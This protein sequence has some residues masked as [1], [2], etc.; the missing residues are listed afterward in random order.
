MVKGLFWNYYYYIFLNRNNAFKIFYSFN[1]MVFLVVSIGSVRNT[2]QCWVIW[3]LS[4]SQPSEELLLFFRMLPTHLYT[5]LW[6]LEWS[7][8]ISPA[9]K[10]DSCVA[11]S[12]GCW[13]LWLV[14]INR[15]SREAW[16][17]SSK[18][19]EIFDNGS[20]LNSKDMSVCVFPLGS[21][22]ISF[23]NTCYIVLI[24]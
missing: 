19:A 11:I 20:T 18:H 7:I 17:L 1:I 2:S 10:T 6:P 9:D 8:A 22:W 3:W 13:W 23:L 14:G 4:A 21:H 12:S 5:D 15:K 16:T 24:Y